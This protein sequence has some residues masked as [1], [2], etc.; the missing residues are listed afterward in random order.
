MENDHQIQENTFIRVIRCP[1]KIF[2][3]TNKTHV[4]NKRRHFSEIFRLILFIHS[5]FFDRNSGKRSRF[6]FNTIF[7][8]PLN[9]NL[10]QPLS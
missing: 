5:V 4:F 8:N 2:N 9:A 6:S 3:D 1:C 10:M 7:G